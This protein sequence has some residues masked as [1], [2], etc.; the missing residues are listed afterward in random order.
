MN[1]EVEKAEVVEKGFLFMKKKVL[2]ITLKAAKPTY[3][4]MADC[5]C[6][7]TNNS[8]ISYGEDN[9][10]NDLFTGIGLFNEDAQERINMAGVNIAY[11][12]HLSR[13]IGVTADAGYYFG[14]QFNTKYSKLQLLAGPSLLKAGPHGKPAFMP[15][16]LL[17]VVNTHQ[18]YENSSS[19]NSSTAV[20]LAIGTDIMMKIGKKKEAGIRVDFNPS[21]LKGSV[22]KSFRLSAGVWF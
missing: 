5:N 12:R 18:K 13:K 16:A 19:S 22:V 1:L 20:A 2:E 15:H 4:V 9:H 11:T 17:G 6:N 7:G 14:K 8:N 10:Q 21:F 3:H